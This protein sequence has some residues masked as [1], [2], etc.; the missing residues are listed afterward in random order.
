VLH[1][2]VESAMYSTSSGCSTIEPVDIA[3]S[4]HKLAVNWLGNSTGAHKGE[5][6]HIVDGDEIV[7]WPARH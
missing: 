3:M 4:P 1:R 7:F 6:R 5:C 2:P